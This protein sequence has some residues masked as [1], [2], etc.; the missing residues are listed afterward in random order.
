MLQKWRILIAAAAAAASAASLLS[1]VVTAGVP[2]V[3]A[4]A[5]AVEV[6]SLA[7][8][9]ALERMTTLQTLQLHVSLRLSDGRSVTLEEKSDQIDPIFA[10]HT[11]A[12]VRQTVAY[13]VIDLLCGRAGNCGA[14]LRK[15]CR[16]RVFGSAC[17]FARVC[18]RVMILM[19]Q[20]TSI[21]IPWSTQPRPRKAKP[22]STVTAE[23]ISD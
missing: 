6:H 23:K 11:A 17:A 4:S 14:L 1:L 7:R 5:A 9:P 2:G 21:F 13:S 18:F 10:L 22:S 20:T 19:H 16:R 12:W 8:P 3:A 15:A